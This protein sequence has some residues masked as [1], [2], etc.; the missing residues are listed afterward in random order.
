MRYLRALAGG[1]VGAVVALLASEYLARAPEVGIGGGG[2]AGV[3]YGLDA[4]ALPAALGFVAGFFLVL[5]SGSKP[6]STRRAR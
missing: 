4:L 5:P 3:S 6:S 1:V 2:I